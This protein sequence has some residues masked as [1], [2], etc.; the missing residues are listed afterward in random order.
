MRPLGLAPLLS[1]KRH[2]DLIPEAQGDCV[3]NTLLVAE[4]VCDHHAVGGGSLGN[5]LNLCVGEGPLRSG[6]GSASQGGKQGEAHRWR[7]LGR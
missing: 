5:N 1:R 3:L 4:G 7:E 6:A 2:L